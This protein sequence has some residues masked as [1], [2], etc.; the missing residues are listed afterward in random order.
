MLFKFLLLVLLLPM[1]KIGRAQKMKSQTAK[2]H[3]APPAFANIAEE[4]KK[5][6]YKAFD[7]EFRLD[8]VTLSKMMVRFR[9]KIFS[10][11]Y[12]TAWS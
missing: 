7:A 3:I 12:R 5:L 6:E 4:I 8:T 1:T 2:H 11:Y 10:G 9:G